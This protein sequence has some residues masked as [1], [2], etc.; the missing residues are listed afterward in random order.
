MIIDEYLL[1]IEY[2]GFLPTLLPSLIAPQAIHLTKCYFTLYGKKLVVIIT[3]GR[4]RR[5]TIIWLSMPL[6]GRP[7]A[8]V[9]NPLYNKFGL[10]L[11]GTWSFHC[12]E[13][14]CFTR[15]K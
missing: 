6:A 15:K 12:G 7:D 11:P 10:N 13:L 8:S 1:A 9:L 5:K 14:R 2:L 3:V 4:K